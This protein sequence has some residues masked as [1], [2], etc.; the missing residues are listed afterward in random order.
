MKKFFLYTVFLS[1]SLLG[2]R[3]EDVDPV[4]GVNDVNSMADTYS[5]EVPLAWT[6]ME[7]RLL[8]GTPNFTPPVAARAIAYFHLAGYEALVGGSSNYQSLVGQL[9]GLTDLPKPDPKL[10]YLWPLAT[11]TAYAFMARQLYLTA[12]PALR[13]S[14]DSMQTTWDARLTQGQPQD[15]VDRSRQYGAAV[16]SALFDYS[17]K[18]G[19]HEGHTRNFPATYQVRRGTGLWEPTENGRRIPLQP[20]WGSNR[21]FIPKNASLA[22]PDILRPSYEKTSPFFAQYKAVYDKN[23]TLTQPE[24]EIAIWWADD[25][26]DTFTPPGHS[27]SIASQVLARERVPMDRTAAILAQVGLAVSDAFVHCWKVKYTH[28]NERPFTYVRKTIDPGWIPFWPAPP[29]P[30]F[31]SGHA[32]QS[33]A[34]AVVLA[35][36]FGENYSFT[37]RTWEGRPRDTA[38]QTDF[39]PR[40]FTS[41]WQSAEESAHSR[42]LG[43]IHTKMDNEAGL[44]QG[45]EIGKHVVELKWGRGN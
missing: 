1:I 8:K 10:G 2:C 32:T 6:Q 24:K 26:S 13:R 33:A 35:N 43:G 22:V 7:L 16:A 11:H 34:M 29:F 4:S 15:L 9:A 21:L 30:G 27:I 39:K 12:P 17:T 38:R 41:F 42:F 19:G 31:S 36:A 5:G 14:I 20:F 40:S 3:V 25:P 28:F 37:D 45:K 23:K 18:D 44:T